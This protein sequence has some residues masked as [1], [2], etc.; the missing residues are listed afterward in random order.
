MKAKHFGGL[1]HLLPATFALR[2]WIKL[3]LLTRLS[4]YQSY[5]LKQCHRNRGEEFSDE[6]A[7]EALLAESNE[8][9]SR[10]ISSLSSRGTDCNG[11][12][13]GNTGV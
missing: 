13:V 8:T 7:A 5:C 1:C 11:S 2:T 12:R 9:L 6:K 10:S 3:T 4:Q